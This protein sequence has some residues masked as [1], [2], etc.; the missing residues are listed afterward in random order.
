[1]FESSQSQSTV[2]C[3]V[4]IVSFGLRVHRIAL[5]GDRL[6]IYIRRAPG[7][8]GDGFGGRSPTLSKVRKEP[9]GEVTHCSEDLVVSRA[10]SNP[11]EPG[12]QTFRYLPL[13]LEKSLGQQFR[14]PDL[15]L[16]LAVIRLIHFITI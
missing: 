5:E 14:K 4:V 10:R 11:C 7:R 8:V 1:M 2:A 16:E 12:F 13:R 9:G 3:V 15:V 6:L